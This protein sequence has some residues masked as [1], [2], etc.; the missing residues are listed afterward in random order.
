MNLIER[1]TT[2]A[3]TARAAWAIAGTGERPSVLTEA[4]V[5][6][7]Q[8][9]NIG[10][11][12]LG[13]KRTDI[14]P[15]S[16][17]KM[18]STA[19]TLYRSNHMAKRLLE[20]IVDFVLG[21]GVKVVARHEDDATR[22][23]IQA[24][25]DD[26]WFD[27]INDMDRKNPQRLTELNLWGEVLM[28]VLVNEHTRR[29]RLGWIDPACIVAVEADKVTREPARVKLDVV[30]AAEVLPGGGEW[31]DVI[32]YSHTDGQIVGDCFFY[33]INSIVSASRGMSE[34]FTSADWFEI[35]DETMK[36]QSDRAKVLL[37]Y[38]WDVTID[39]A[40]A[41]TIAAFTKQQ[42][43]PRP[44]SMR[45]H[46]QKVHWEAKAPNLAAYETS[47]QQRD[48]KSYLLGGFGYPSHWFGSGDEAN[49]ATAEMMSEPTRKALKRKTRQFTFM[50]KDVCRFVL[51]QAAQPGGMLA[52]LKGFNPMES[53]FEITVP[54]IGGPDVAKVG[55]ALQQVTTAIGLAQSS[56]L[57][58][59]ETAREMFAAVASLMGVEVNPVL[60]GEK[61]DAMKAEREQADAAQE[62]QR[63]QE[64]QDALASLTK[65]APAEGE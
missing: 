43:R 28:P 20:I 54:D 5:S 11:T 53:C 22:D 33:Q 32:R 37:E 18:L 30:T 27:P 1:L 29:V 34:F 6:D 57:V 26:F 13:S 48:L 3:S 40:D 23:A 15:Y 38:I 61:L 50:L 65:Q 2:A 58:T 55:A 19:L 62:A 17:E 35:L 25:L 51:V 44:G 52:G 41:A 60:E 14:T 63:Q 56:N 24:C 46:N 16:Q 10:Y 59:D 49:L 31:L 45:V 36:V 64:T 39:D 12:A 42:R 8:S 4:E 21:D 9:E 47:R 7:L